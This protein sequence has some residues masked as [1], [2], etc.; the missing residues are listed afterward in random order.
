MLAACLL[1]SNSIRWSKFDPLYKVTGGGVK[2]FTSLKHNLLQQ[3]PYSP[4]QLVGPTVPRKLLLPP[5]PLRCASAAGSA[6]A[7]SPTA[8]APAA[9]YWCYQCDRF[10]RA[11]VEGGD[12][13][14]PACPAAAASSRRWARRLLGPPTSAARARHH[15]H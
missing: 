10:V 11:A 4:S 7:S 8:A 2:K 9:A 15:H 1:E 13:T 3:F 6:M 5:P 12:S 14:Y